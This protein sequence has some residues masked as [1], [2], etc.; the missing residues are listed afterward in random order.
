MPQSWSMTRMPLRESK[1][2]IKLTSSA[3]VP[4]GKPQDQARVWK[5]SRTFA[6]RGI[7]QID[8][9]HVEESYGEH[10]RKIAERA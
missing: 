4:S 6:V 2:W 10:Q 3:L 5:P 7:L 1:K 8:R 9:D